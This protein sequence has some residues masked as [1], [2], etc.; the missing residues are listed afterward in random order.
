MA[1]VTARV[2]TDLPFGDGDFNGFGE[3]KGG[4]Y[5]PGKE[6]DEKDDEVVEEGLVVLE[7]VG[8]EAFQIVLEE[9]E[10][11]E[12]G[13]ALLDGDVPGQHHDEVEQDAGEPDGAAQD[14]PLAAEAGKEKDDG[15]SEEGSYRAFGE[16]GGCSE[17]V[18]VEEPEL[19]PG[20]VPCVPAEH[21]DAEGCGEL[22]VGGGAAGEADDGDAG[23]GDEGCVEMAP[24]AES[25]HVEEDEDDEGE[26]GG[27]GRETSGP[28]RDAEFLEEAHG[29]PVIE[30]GFFEPWLAVEDRSDGSGGDAVEGGADIFGAQAPGDHLGVNGVAGVGVGGEHL[31]GDLCV[32][33]LIG[34]YEAE[35]VAAEDGNETVEQKEGSYGKEN[36]KF[37]Y[38]GRCGQ[39]LPQPNDGCVLLPFGRGG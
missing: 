22:H 2:V 32:T 26:G 21:A 34:A 8:S 20:F 28:V 5:G 11:V 23:D 37:T 31:A 30:G 4:Y 38:R 16:G 18:E 36:G 3:F 6:T 14:G 13:I 39:L 9:E 10:A 17:E 24:G 35:L 1:E 12:G 19:F 33:G 25:T 15:E 7:T 29:S 27:G